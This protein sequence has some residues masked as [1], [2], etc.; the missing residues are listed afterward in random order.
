M[1]LAIAEDHRALAEVAGAMVAGRGGV[2]GARR[3]LLGPDTVGRWWTED[4]LWKEIV[5]TGWLGLHIDE[6]Y[7]GQ[8]YGLPELTIVLEQLGRAAIG[9]PF[10]PTVAVSAVI[11]EIGTDEQRRHW[12]P[13]LASGDIVA[14]IGTK[15]DAAVAD[16]RVTALAV[17]TLAEAA[18]DVFLLPV[19]DDLVL[20]R[21]G[22]GVS[23]RNIDSVDLLLRPVTV[24]SL[25]SAE[26]AEVFPGAAAAA[27]RLIRLLAAAEAVGGL[28]ACTEM[29]TG[30]AAAREQFG[31]P[32]GSFQAVKHHCANMLVDTELAVAA[33][34]DAARA[35]GAEAELAVGMAAGHALAAYQRVALLNVQVHGGIGYTWEHDAHL[36]VRRA[37]VLQTFAGDQ[38]A[39][40]DRVVELQVHG[41]RRGHSVDLPPEAEQYRQAANDFRA[42][43]EAADAESAQKLW[44]RSGYLQPHWPEPYGRNADSTE[45]LIIEEVLD[46]VD[47]PSLGLG[48]WVVPTLLQ[49][50]SAEQIER[51]MWPSLEGE[52]R[53]C[54][55]FSEPGAGSDAAAVATKGR[56]V[57]GGWVVT[58][59]KVWTSDAVNCQRGL[60]TV[61]TDPDVPKHKGITAMVIDLA[62]PAVQI[63]PLTEITGETLFNEVFFDDVFVPDRDVVGPVNAGWGVAMAAFGN[64][65]VSIGGGSVTMTAD[66]LI[67][68]LTAHRPGD[69][70]LARDVGALLIEAY[71]LAALN[72]RQAARAVFDSGPGIEGNIA[73]LFGAEHAQRVAELALRLAGPAILLGEEPTVVHDYLFSRCL[74]IAGGTSEIVRNLIAERIL[75][76]PRDPAPR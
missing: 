17:P 18:A 69:T 27:A 5:S 21:S 31:R 57:D 46:G 61:R 43:V 73:K 70:G 60:A 20:V 63:R 15:S 9:G 1:A 12:L 16:S 47:K 35:E 30:Y 44:A 8:G 65:R 25:A 45:Q 71:T 10:L 72:L 29:A 67:D 59:Q 56:R 19:G 52:V 42:E 3:I 66:A 33:T 74:T 68:L 37:T 53:W 2:A 26:I 34:W 28:G 50:G 23:T 14:G 51:L 41:V 13:Q 6:R 76:L 62:D 38:E 75:G 54:Q 48:E 58:G 11:A 22:D 7:G 64:E 24:V 36:Y 39:L 40:R 32:I 4:G 55:L 49:H